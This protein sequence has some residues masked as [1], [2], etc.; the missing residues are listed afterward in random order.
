MNKDEG[1]G[2]FVM[3]IDPGL[4]VGRDAYLKG[5]T[6][7]VKAVTSA[8]PLPGQ[9]VLLPGERGDHLTHKSTERNEIEIADAIWD[10]LVSFVDAQ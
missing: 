10:Q 9:Q 7:L 3:A 1:A 2:T 6:E 5:A 8:K 4:L